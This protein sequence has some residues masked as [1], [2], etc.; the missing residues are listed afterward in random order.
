MDLWV[1]DVDPEQAT[2]MAKHFYET[3]RLGPGSARSRSS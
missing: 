1:E 2:G 3:V